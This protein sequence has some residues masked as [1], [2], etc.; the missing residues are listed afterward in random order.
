LKI[1]VTGG[2][3]FIG[4]HLI[5]RLGP[6]NNQVIVLDN[7][8][9]GLRENIPQSLRSKNVQLMLGDC[10]NPPDVKEAMKNIDVVFHL[11]ANPEVRLELNDPKTCFQHNVYATHILLEELRK[12]NAHTLVFTSTSTVYGDAE[13]IPTPETHPTRPISLYGASK[14][15]S[16]ALITSYAYTYNKK[17]IILRLAN[18]VGPRSS[19]GVIHDFIIKLKHDPSKLEIL[20]DGTQTKSYLYIDDCINA[21]L[22]ALQTNEQVSTLNIGSEDQINV[23]DIARIVV[24]EMRLENVAFAFTGGVDG[25]RGWKGDVKNMM[26]D[27]GRLKALGWKPI[28]RS[29]EAVRLSTSSYLHSS[30]VD[31]PSA[32]P[33][34]S[35]TFL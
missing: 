5:D 27:I 31:S 7:Q 29:E 17:A 12:S 34:R 16:E 26:L 10:T 9:S 28:L 32:L 23:K 21:I 25:G 22:T 6:L 2:L 4:S 24:E 30:Y 33:Y 35:L 13:I 8:S 3:G 11:A 14:L 18:V 1:L 15:A 20:G 19:H